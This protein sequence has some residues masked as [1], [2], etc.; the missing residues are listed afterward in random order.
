MGLAKAAGEYGH[1]EIADLFDDV[2]IKVPV[3]EDT[4]GL[5]IT[6]DGTGIADH[7]QLASGIF[8]ERKYAEEAGL[9][10][11]DYH[12]QDRMILLYMS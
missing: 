4:K 12:P 3:D 5:R 2:N 1:P 10:G 8:L 6:V 7:V 11:E 9:D